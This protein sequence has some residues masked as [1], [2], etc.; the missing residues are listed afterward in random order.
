MGRSGGVDV[1]NANDV[2]FLDLRD[3]IFCLWE[4]VPRPAEC[5][6]REPR[7]D[8]N[9]EVVGLDFEAGSRDSG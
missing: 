4:G 8:Q 7:V 1:A 6:V 9:V 5:A 2:W 3:R